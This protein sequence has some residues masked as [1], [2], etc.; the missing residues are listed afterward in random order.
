MNKTFVKAALVLVTFSA[1]GQA[2]Q[3]SAEETIRVEVEIARVSNNVILTPYVGVVE[4]EQRTLVSFTGMGLLKEVLVREGQAVR[5]GQLLAR[6]DDTQARNA[7]DA[8]Q[9]TLRQALDAQERMKQ[10]RDNNALPEIKW[11][12]VESRVQQ[13]QASVAMCQKS[14]DDCRLLSPCN[15]VVGGEI[16]HP[17]ETVLPTAPVL[18]IL[19]I[20][21]VKVRASVPEKEISHLTATTV[22]TV[23][24]DALPGE[25]FLGSTMEKAVSADVVTHTYDIRIPLDN[26]DMRLLPGM[27]AK[28]VVQ[29][30]KDMKLSLPVRA[31][32][33]NTENGLYVWMVRH[34][35]AIAVPVT[36]GEPTANRIEVTGGIAEGDTVIVEG[37]HK[38]GMD[39][40][41]QVI[42]TQQA[43]H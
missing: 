1:C 7:L 37:Y 24:L 41:V 33:Q 4:P 11:V 16:M 5:R 10:L 3:R 21:R 8:A 23:E 35:K 25:T 26:P 22:S 29:N 34:G 20:A 13:A 32:Q 39:T 6:I 36:V 42:A 9:S 38:V 19:S 31:V 40:P 2:P 18:S 14:L 17:G 15:G 28:V 12:E 30:P 43:L 27:V